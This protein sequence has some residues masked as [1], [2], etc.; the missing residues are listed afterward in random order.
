MKALSVLALVSLAV[1]AQTPTTS[2]TSGLQITEIT[3]KKKFIR[4]RGLSG[5]MVSHDPPVLDNSTIMIPGPASSNPTIRNQTE[6]ANINSSA[7][8]VGSSPNVSVVWDYRG[9]VYDFQAQVKNDG[10][11][12]ITRFV[13]AYT[14]P[15][16]AATQETVGQ[17]YLCRVRIE[18]G[19]TK[20]IQVRS[21]IPRPKT[22]D[23]SD[24]SKPLAEHQPVLDDMSVNQIEFGDGTLWRRS[25]WNPVVLTRLGARKL[26]KGKCIAL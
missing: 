26:R 24:I 4:E 18:P 8:R 17:E 13:W 22:V 14:V 23:I 7:R 1:V 11:K 5:S 12:P 3:F 21:P 25:N 19:E 20:A 10:A 6:K 2:G 16:E 9:W 15:P